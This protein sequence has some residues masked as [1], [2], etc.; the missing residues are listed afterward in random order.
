MNYYDLP[1]E[2]MQKAISLTRDNVSRSK[3]FSLTL[4]R[5]IAYK[6]EISADA[7]CEEVKR[8]ACTGYFDTIV[9]A[10]NSLVSVDISAVRD[11]TRAWVAFRYDNLVGNIPAPYAREGKEI[12]DFFGYSK[13]F[14]ED[15]IKSV[16]HGMDKIVCLH[17][18]LAPIVCH[19]CDIHKKKSQG[20]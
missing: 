9:S 16:I 11:Y 20:E 3:E 7:T 12:C 18:N 1:P 4:A 6:V 2:L 17:N 15:T 5:I 14:D 13:H 10:V 8:G 19:I